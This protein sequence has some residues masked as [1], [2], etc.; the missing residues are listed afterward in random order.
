MT[1]MRTIA[2][3]GASLVVITL[4]G[5]A[6]ER[7]ILYPN[8]KLNEAG[9]SVAQADVDECIAKA[10]SSGAKAHGGGPDPKD[11]AVNTG[12]GAAVG[13]ATGA[14]F[15]RPGRGAAAGAA[16]AATG[17]VVRG[18]LRP[19]GN[20]THR[21]FVELCLQEKGYQIVGWQ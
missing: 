7:P 2:S 5:C 17:T 4:A 3:L 9:A 21:R 19:H 14:V 13:A 18:V 10:Q 8:A 20:P 12:T 11:V 15:G 6:A 16:G 1:L